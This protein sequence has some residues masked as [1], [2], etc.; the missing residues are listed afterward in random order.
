MSSSNLRGRFREVLLVAVMLTSVMTE[1]N[2]YDNTSLAP[3]F[4]YLY[5]GHRGGY[6]SSS[7]LAG[8]SGSPGSRGPS[9]KPGVQVPQGIY[10]IR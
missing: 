7:G 1:D 10:Q 8:P 5:N 2:T 4:Q 9:A 6:P 3:G